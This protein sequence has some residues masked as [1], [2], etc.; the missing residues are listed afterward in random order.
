LNAVSIRMQ[1]QTSQVAV[2]AATQFQ[3]AQLDTNNKNY[4]MARQRLEYVIQLDPNFPGAAQLLTQVLV[5]ENTIATNTPLPPTPTVIVTPTPDFRG[6]DEIYQHAYNLMR[7]KDWFN[8]LDTLDILRNKNRAF[9]ALEVDGLYYMG[10]RQRGVTK[11][12][13][14]NLEEGIYDLSL[15]ERYGP[16]DGEADGLRSSARF[17]LLGATFWEVDWSKVVNYFG[18]LYPLLPSLR[19]SSGWTVSE[20]FRK[21]SIFYGNQLM[22]AKKY[23]EGRNQYQSALGIANDDLLAPTA[24]KA[25]LLCEPPTNTPL[26]V[27]ETP[28][29][30]VT[31]EFVPPTDTETPTETLTP[32]S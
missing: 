11:I 13:M 8:A 16:I 32:E 22:E 20:R 27:T 26:P 7:A 1:Q 2:L 14:G 24:T 10:L 5:E 19:D 15:T 25:Q 29:P 12:L 30:T 3:L 28:T 31:L 6:E 17:Y 4:K 23:C 18:Q 9:K 21:G